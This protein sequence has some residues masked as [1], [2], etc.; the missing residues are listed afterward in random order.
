MSQIALQYESE[1]TEFSFD[2]FDVALDTAAMT[3]HTTFTT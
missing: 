3:Q 2:M 1:L